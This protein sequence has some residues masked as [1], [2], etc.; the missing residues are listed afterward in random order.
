[1]DG[2][3]AALLEDF[4]DAVNDQASHYLQRIQQASQRMGQLIEDLLHLSRVTRR[5]INYETIDLSA[6]AI[7]ISRELE[8]QYQDRNIK[9]EIEQ[10]I[11]V[12]ADA[13]LMRIALENLISNAVKFSG[14]KKRA[15]ITIGVLHNEKE[16]V[17][18]VKDNGVGF[19]MKY[20]DKLFNPF[21]RL[22][23][24]DE[25]PGT[26]I[27]LVTVQRIINRHGGT[28]WPEAKLNK[29]ATFYFTL[30]G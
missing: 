20:S 18:Y 21:Q 19:N 13:Q 27:G 4:P 9:F 24:M 25:F 14:N 16:T 5:E 8:I 28:I 29:G 22:H 10:P 2:F 6:I 23:S 3:S 26:G 7:D 17:Y 11:H 30:G 1:M 12:T 15:K